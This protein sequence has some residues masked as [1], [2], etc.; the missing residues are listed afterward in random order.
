LLDHR[1]LADQ[2]YAD[3]EAFL[4]QQIGENL[5]LDYKRELSTSSNRDR[6]ELCK[7]ISAFAN[8]QGGMII[9][10]VGEDSTDRTP[11]LPP[12]GTPRTVGSR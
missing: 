7:D 1:P 5:T 2:T 4:Q 12:A 9:Y 8:S 10:G 6:A 11:Q 3:L